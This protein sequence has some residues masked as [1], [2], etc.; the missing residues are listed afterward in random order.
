MEVLRIIIN[1]A[2]PATFATIVGEVRVNAKLG[3]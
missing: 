2:R 3:G 1:A